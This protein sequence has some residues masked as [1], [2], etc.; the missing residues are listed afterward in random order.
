VKRGH[1]VVFGVRDVNVEG[2]TLLAEAGANARAGN[3]ARSSNRYRC[4]RLST[5]VGSSARSR[6]V[7]RGPVDVQ[8]LVNNQLDARQIW[9]I[10]G[11]EQAGWL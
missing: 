5:D 4:D 3:S 10:S 9:G 11:G 1:E 6:L 2:K 8:L 7:R